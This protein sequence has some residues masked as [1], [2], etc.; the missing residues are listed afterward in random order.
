MGTIYF[1][2]DKTI[3]FKFTYLILYFISYNWSLFLYYIIWNFNLYYT[4]I[5]KKLWRGIKAINFQLKAYLPNF[6][7]TLQYTKD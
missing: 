3:Y 2:F 7:I 5:F 1:K 4:L 6:C